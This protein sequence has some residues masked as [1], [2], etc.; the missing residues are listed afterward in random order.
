MLNSKLFLLPSS[1]MLLT[2]EEFA[3]SKQERHLAP[4]DCLTEVWE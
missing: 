3:V 1:K 2:A 4:E